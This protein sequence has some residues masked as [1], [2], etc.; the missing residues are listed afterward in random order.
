MSKDPTQMV[1]VKRSLLQSMRVEFP[2]FT[3]DNDRIA[4]IFE[5]HKKTQ[6]MINGIGGFIYG[7]KNWKKVKIK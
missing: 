4:N 1:R 5:Q 3:T 6:G 2:H 7:R